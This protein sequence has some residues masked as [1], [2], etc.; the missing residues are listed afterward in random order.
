MLATTEFLII[1]FKFCLY[2]LS[3]GYRYIKLLSNVLEWQQ[4]NESRYE[5]RVKCE[6]NSDL[7]C[8]N[9]YSLYQSNGLRMRA[10]LRRN[11]SILVLQNP[12]SVCDRNG[13]NLLMIAS[14]ENSFCEAHKIK[15]EMVEEREE[16]R[17][18]KRKRS[19]DGREKNKKRH[20]D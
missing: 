10:R 3:F 8:P 6:S 4:K 16:E 2:I 15:V 18:G 9:R 14:K 7:S 13:N 5:V 19:D 11:P 17:E 20:E 12:L 1:L